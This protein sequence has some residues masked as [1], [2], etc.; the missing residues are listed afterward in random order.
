MYATGGNNIL[1]NRETIDHAGLLMDY[2]NG[3]KFA[4]NFSIFASGSIA[5]AS[6]EMMVLVVGYAEAGRR[7]GSRLQEQRRSG[8]GGGSGHGKRPPESGRHLPPI[9][10]VP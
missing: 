7:E 1:K 2:E 8:K 10:G 6:S 5:R 9:S 3:V 4:F